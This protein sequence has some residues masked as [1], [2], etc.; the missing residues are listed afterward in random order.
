MSVY[1]G[2]GI[3]VLEIQ[4]RL[5]SFL[6]LCT[7]LILHDISLHDMTIPTQPPAPLD[8]NSWWPSLARSLAEPPYNLPDPCDFQYLE[9]LLH[10]KRAEAMDYMWSLREDPGYF[11]EMVHDWSEHRDEIF[12]SAEGKRQPMYREVIEWDMT[13][14]DVIASAY[15]DLLLWNLALAHFSELR[16]IGARHGRLTL[17]NKRMVEASRIEYAHF[18]YLVTRMQ[19]FSLGDLKA[20]IFAS[21]AIRVDYEWAPGGSDT[22]DSR[23]VRRCTKRRDYLLDLIDAIT[24]WTMVSRWGLHNILDELE[25]VLQSDGKQRK[26]ISTWVTR[27]ISDLTIAAELERQMSLYQPEAW[28]KIFYQGL[29][30]ELMLDEYLRR[31]P[32]VTIVMQG[33]KKMRLAEGVSFLRKCGY[34]S[35]KTRTAQRT[36][37]MI[38]AETALDAVWNRVDEEFVELTEEKELHDF[39]RIIFPKAEWTRELRRTPEWSQ[40]VLQTTQGRSPVQATHDTFPALDLENRTR[41]KIS[42]SEAT[43]A[44]AK[45]KTRGQATESAEAAIEAEAPNPPT[46]P[47]TISVHKRAYKTFTTFFH[48]SDKDELPGE[49]SWLDFLQAM[50]SAGFAVEK[51]DGSAWMFK[52]QNDVQRGIIFHEPHPHSKIP[53]S[54]ARRHGRRLQRAYGWTGKTSVGAGT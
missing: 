11:R 31:T 45:V 21:P 36:R 35:D 33:M 5:L 26:R 1:P 2:L 53:L 48:T 32:W 24:D 23:I 9:A 6:K 19:I 39:L 15:R 46:T 49:I 16:A 43:P 4:Q 27:F 13:A 8:Q 18:S 40:P 44:K 37:E 22:T 34:P 52:P 30:E 47:L 50:S 42:T 14:R 3:L 17:D 28:A 29:T 10:A 41:R 51:L 12:F 38:E 54:I 20:G 25:R 7:E